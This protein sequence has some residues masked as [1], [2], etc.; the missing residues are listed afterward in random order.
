MFGKIFG[1]NKRACAEKRIIDEKKEEQ[2]PNLKKQKSTF[3][4]KTIL[5][6]AG[7]W[8]AWNTYTAAK[9]LED[10]FKE[11]EIKEDKIELT[12]PKGST[13][14]ELVKTIYGKWNEQTKKIFQED[15]QH[16]K[17]LNLIRYNIDKLNFRTE[18]ITKEAMEKILQKAEIIPIKNKLF[19]EQYK[20]STTI[21]ENKNFSTILDVPELKNT[22]ST[23]QY[24]S[25]NEK[26][27]IQKQENK[28]SNKNI[29]QKINDILTKRDALSLKNEVT[30]EQFSQLRKS[31]QEQKN[32][33]LMSAFQTSK[34]ISEQNREKLEQKIRNEYQ[35]ENTHSIS[36]NTT[37]ILAINNNKFQ[38]N[39]I[40]NQIEN[41]QI[42]E[43]KKTMS[44]IFKE[45]KQKTQIAKI[46]GAPYKKTPIYNLDGTIKFFSTELENP[47]YENDLKSEIESKFEN[48][49]NAL[50]LETD[51]A[52]NQQ[53]NKLENNLP[54]EEE[55][56]DIEPEKL[57]EGF[58]YKY[59]AGPRKV[60]ADYKDSQSATLASMTNE[61][62]RKQ[63]YNF[64]EF[65]IGKRVFAPL[66]GKVVERS[67]TLEERFTP[68]VYKNK[69]P[70]QFHTGSDL[71]TLQML[72]NRDDPKEEP[73]LSPYF[74]EVIGIGRSSNN[75]KGVYVDILIPEFDAEF[76][77]Y[78]MEPKSNNHL[79]IGSK[80]EPGQVIGVVGE[81]GKATGPH[82]HTAITTTKITENLNKL[83][84]G[85]NKSKYK[86]IFKKINNTIYVNPSYVFENAYKENFQEL[87]NMVS[88][89]KSIQR[90]KNKYYA[91]K[92]TKNKN[93]TAATYN[94]QTSPNEGIGSVDESLKQYQN[95]DTSKTLPTQTIPSQTVDDIIKSS[96]NSE[97]KH[98]ESTIELKQ[99]SPQTYTPK[100]TQKPEPQA[101]IYDL[102]KNIESKTINTENK[103]ENFKIYALVEETSGAKKRRHI[104]SDKYLSRDSTWKKHSEGLSRI[105]LENDIKSYYSMYFNGIKTQEAEIRKTVDMLETRIKN[106]LNY[107]KVA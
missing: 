55:I 88:Y 93:L 18:K 74:G 34:T 103:D 104:I 42:Y 72:E 30:L 12:V 77:A 35:Q 100:P 25:L 58:T 47:K 6:A 50:N 45:A 31:I 75:T 29:V 90:T 61:D 36:Q 102:N 4:K 22:L 28:Y 23:K 7:L 69:G 43:P 53:M 95:Q 79:K 17:D 40:S 52:M 26:E 63:G 99:L 19:E 86:N 15:N 106:K 48:K 11:F 98:D 1:R 80:V 92:E 5:G 66:K 44:E 70:V 60:E 64:F 96:L 27:Q 37:T 33:D 39:D 101:T 81:T 3:L 62:L 8:M 49:S 41:K 38:D 54:V 107:A 10:P 67:P 91:S 85:V 78:H 9:P 56:F 16:I 20:I 73:V 97:T 87:Q 82:L 89:R 65:D 32:K 13:T 71:K 84:V 51:L 46:E 68:D 14:S 24:V 76:H 59:P 2:L 94:S 83:T 57:K 21:N 105:T